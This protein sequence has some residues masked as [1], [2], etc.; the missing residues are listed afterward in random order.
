M[1]PQPPYSPDLAPCDFFLFPKLKRPIKGRRYATLD[2]IKTASKEELKKILKNDFLK[3][4]EDW[5]N[6]WHKKENIPLD[7]I[8]DDLTAHL[9]NLESLGVNT[10]MAG[11]FL[12]P[13][14]ESSLPLDIIQVWQKNPAVGYGIKEEEARIEISDAGGRLQAL[15]DFLQDEVKGDERLAFAKE[16]FDGEDLTAVETKLEWTLMGQSPVVCKEDK[17]QIALNMLVARNNLKDLWELDVLGIQD[18]IEVVS[19]KE[20]GN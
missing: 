17:V 6:C 7:E 13:L 8:Y 18:P 14:V 5:K 4:F 20:K 2:E 11:V 3:C 1:M 19:K 16:N 9:K 10:E 12:Y 15:M